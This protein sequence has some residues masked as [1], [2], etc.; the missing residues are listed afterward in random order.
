MLYGGDVPGSPYRD[1]FVTSRNTFQKYF[2]QSELK[3]Y[4]EQVL[5]RNAFMVGP[6]IALVFASSEAEQRFSAGRYRRKNVALRLL[7]TRAAKPVKPKI[8]REPKTR[9]ERP[10]RLSQVDRKFAAA[11]PL[12][13]TLWATT[14]DLGRIPEAD[15]DQSD[16]MTNVLGVA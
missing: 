2:A 4:I 7:V 14:L 12:L 15:E 3:D 13:D 8:V 11:K 6:G 1:G 5:Q 16:E 10:A 9:E